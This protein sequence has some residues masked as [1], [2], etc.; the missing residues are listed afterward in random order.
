MYNTIVGFMNENLFSK[1]LDLRVRLFNVL[2]LAGIIISGM[3]TIL[4]PLI[5]KT[6]LHMVIYFGYCVLSVFLL[7]YSIKTGKYQLCYMITIVV[8]FMIG[9]PIFFFINDIYYSSIPYYFIF[10]VVFTIFM[11][12][13][14]K[15]IIFAVIELIIYNGI[16]IYSAHYLTYIK[17]TANHISVMRGVTFVSIALG[18]AMYLQF[19]LYN[20]QQKE[21][22]KA[23][24]MLLE[25]NAALEH[26]NQLKTEFLGN[27]SHELKTPLTVVSG[28]AQTSEMQLYGQQENEAVIN[29]MKLIS[30]E[31]ERLALMV[32]QIL[33]LTRIEE[34]R[35]ILDRKPCRIDEIIQIAVDTHFPIL[36]KNNNRLILKIDSGL[37]KIYADESR[38]VQV[39]VNLVAN[40]IRFTNSGT[41]TIFAVYKGNYVEVSVCDTGMGI[42]SDRLSVIFERYNQSAKN[43]GIDTGTG[44]GLYICKHIIEEHGGT[45]TVES[46][47]EKGSIFR[48]IVPVAD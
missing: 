42:E 39:I 12:E 9:F 31:A 40:A 5:D 7:H 35:M 15:A 20:A 21:L 33:D 4:S 44:L 28:Y 13:G 37:P 16:C 8:I 41:I 36:N 24:K 11:L 29:K 46:E 17:N 34:G 45:I 25:E 22:E 10:A 38:I 1:N 2:A 43:K 23:R 32:G 47:L 48:F 14:K 30:S 18:S 19:R 27:V 6:F 26:L 3:A